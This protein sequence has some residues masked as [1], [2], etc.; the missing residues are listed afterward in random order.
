MILIAALGTNRVVGSGEGMPWNVPEEYAHGSVRFSLSR[1]TTA[2]EIVAALEMI[3][4][5]V[6]KLR[7]SL[8]A[9]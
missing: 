7:D 6:G 8:S 9:V 4:A 2:D 1:D 3:T 5:A